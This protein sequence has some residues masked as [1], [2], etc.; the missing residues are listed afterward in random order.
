M[1]H[2]MSSV[3][4]HSLR[5]GRPRIFGFE[6]GGVGGGEGAVREDETYPVVTDR[7]VYGC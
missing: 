2:G 3:A 6:V 5:I 4:W 1:K 7:D